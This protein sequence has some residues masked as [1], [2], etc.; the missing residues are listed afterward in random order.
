MPQKIDRELGSG[1]DASSLVVRPLLRRLERLTRTL[2]GV[3]FKNADELWQFQVRLLE[4]QRDIQSEINKSKSH[5]RRDKSKIAVLSE[6][7]VTRWHARR[8]GD[9][10]A[11]IVMGLNRKIIYPLS[12]NSRVA[13]S[14]ENHGSRGMLVI[15]SHLASLGWGFPVIHDVTDCLRIGDITF[16]H[17]QDS[18]R[19]YRT[20][21]IKTSLKAERTVSAENVTHYEYEVQVISP[22]PFDPET[23]IEIG[24]D[25]VGKP[26]NSSSGPAPSRRPDRRIGRQARRMSKALTHQTAPDNQLTEIEGEPPLLSTTMEKP[27]PSYWKALRRVI[28]QARKEGYASECIEGAFLYTAFYEA[29]GITVPALKSAIFVEDIKN[30]GLLIEGD[31]VRNALII[32]AIPPQEQTVSHAFLPYYLYSIPQRAIYDLIYGRLVIVVVVNQG[33]ISQALEKAGFE[34]VKPPDR[35]DRS[36]IV[37]GSIVTSSGA[38]YRVDIPNLPLHLNEM[39]YEFRGVDYLT[40][41][42][43]SILQAAAKVAIPDFDQ[44]RRK[45][46]T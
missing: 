44:K 18:A 43:T 12:D 32:N 13:V 35:S 15:A 24:W 5:L 28:R 22:I 31:Q 11:W 30:S 3:R 9:A 20:V 6:L 39:V 14:R 29:E 2:L 1:G 26:V 23:G 34:I 17:T 19:T 33:R 46:N 4:L 27:T 8:L 37:S 16:V 41:V 38:R 10:Y 42:A 25:R 40:G 36:F 7:R 45:A 21:E